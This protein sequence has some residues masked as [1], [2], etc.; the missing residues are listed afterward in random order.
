M[1]RILKLLLLFLVLALV[2]DFGL[3]VAKG[4][5]RQV[6]PENN[7]VPRNPMFIYKWQQLRGVFLRCTGG[8]ISKVFDRS[9]RDLGVLKTVAIEDEK[10]RVSYAVEFLEPE[11]AVE[12][13][14]MLNC[15]TGF[16]F[17]ADELVIAS[18]SKSFAKKKFTVTQDVYLRS[19]RNELIK[20]LTGIDV[21]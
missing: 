2:W 12:S 6:L 10:S 20:K 7:E 3:F 1:L 11:Y 13:E 15:N 16:P 21:E 14:F 8:N 9:G 17:L 5:P 18:F 4:I 19:E